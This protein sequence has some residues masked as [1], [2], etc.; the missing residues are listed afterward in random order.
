[1]IK[2]IVLLSFLVISGGAFAQVGINNED[3]KATLD[4][5]A[6]TTDGSKPEGVIA[7]RLTGDQ[8]K[9]A[10]A[11]YIA[12]QTGAMVYATAAVGTS[13]A[14]TV[15]ITTPGYY[16]FNGTVWLK[17]NDI[18]RND[19]VNTQVKLGTLS[20]G[21]TARPTGTDFVVK[22]NGRVGI[23]STTPASTLDVVATST[24]AT[25]PE[26][27]IAPRLTGD[28]IKAKDAQYIAAQTGAIVFATAAVGT[29]TAKTVNITTSGYY[30]FNGT[31][32]LKVNDVWRNDTANTQIKLGT[33]SNGTSARTAGTEFVV[34]DTGNV[35]IGTTTPTSNLDINGSFSAAIRTVSVA[36]T[37]LDSDYTILGPTTGPG[38]TNP[39]IT[40]TMPDPTTMKGRIYN[41]VYNGG[42]FTLS[43]LLRVEGA[44]VTS[45][46]IRATLS[47]AIFQSDGTRWI[48]VNRSGS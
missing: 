40:I 1:M 20:N 42:N 4:I 13:T 7:P 25:T 18:W 14:K 26:G 45:F 33:L 27:I 24:A 30:F 8:I 39:G 38:G 48:A 5:T 29:S 41:F 21:T 19:V 2:N 3:P 10:D 44:D 11:Q 15:N 9:A 34:L 36:T 46:L 31:V 22:D 17:V 37:I 35:G 28:Q 47:A 43:G 16:F 23:A 12:A 6:K 32:W